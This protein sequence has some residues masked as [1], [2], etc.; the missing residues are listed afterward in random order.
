MTI[1]LSLPEEEQR[2]LRLIAIRLDRKLLSR[3]DPVDVLQ[4]AYIDALQRVEPLFL[5]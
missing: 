2:L 3:V 4:E 1:N 5:T